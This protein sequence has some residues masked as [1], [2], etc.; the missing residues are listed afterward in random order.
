MV[1]KILLIAFLMQQTYPMICLPNKYWFI[2]G[3]ELGLP[4]STCSEGFKELSKDENVEKVL[5]GGPVNVDWDRR[6]DPSISFYYK[7]GHFV[8][9]EITGDDA[10]IVVTRHL[11]MRDDL[12]KGI[13]L[14]ICLFCYCL[15]TI[16][17]DNAIIGFLVSLGYFI[18]ILPL[19][20]LSP[21][22]YR[23]ISYFFSEC[24][25]IQEPRMGVEFVFW[26]LQHFIY[27]NDWIR[28]RCPKDLNGYLP[29]HLIVPHNRTLNLTTPTKLGVLHYGDAS[30]CNDN[31]CWSGEENN[32]VIDN[33]NYYVINTTALDG[34]A[35][36]SC[37]GSPDDNGYYGILQEFH[38]GYGM[39]ICSKV[40]PTTRLYMTLEV[41]T[42]G[43]LVC[44]IIVYIFKDS[45]RKS[46]VIVGLGILYTCLILLI[47]LGIIK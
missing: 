11:A 30:K 37:R 20:S 14:S 33:E 1:I 42:F 36:L 45:L 13:L 34:Q 8:I 24:T 39:P 12:W 3:P 27:I 21:T 7:N 32:V 18:Y 43:P 9:E 31:L 10:I 16:Y 19:L 2:L 22:P 25:T 29:E 40:V 4:W 47:N 46:Q 44:L 15:S 41:Y 6:L 5:I 28:L 23:E 17:F 35:G 26:P 38:A